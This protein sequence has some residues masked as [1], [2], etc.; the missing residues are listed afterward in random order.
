MDP[1]LLVGIAASSLAF[2][3]EMLGDR[4]LSST[5]RTAVGACF[6]LAGFVLGAGVIAC[7]LFHDGILPDDRRLSGWP[8]LFSFGRAF[9][10]GPAL[11]GCPLIAA[12]LLLRRFPRP[13]A[14]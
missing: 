2:A 7:Y 5:R 10:L 12:G 11:L 13:S 1:I 4:R 3:A 14:H 6:A 9:M 8:S